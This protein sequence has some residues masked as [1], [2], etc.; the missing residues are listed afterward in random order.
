MCS[1]ATGKQQVLRSAQDDNSCLLGMTGLWGWVAG[2][3]CRGS[4]TR[5]SAPHLNH[6]DDSSGDLL[7]EHREPPRVAGKQQVR[8]FAH[9]DNVYLV[10]MTLLFRMT[11]NRATSLGF[12]RFE[13]V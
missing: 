10:Q 13:T 7:L 4:R 8:R 9:N 3:C 12:S 2:G 1:F 5:V 6:S 11:P